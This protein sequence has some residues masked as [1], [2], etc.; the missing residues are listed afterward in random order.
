LTK[1]KEYTIGVVYLALTALC[2]GF[3][4]STVKRLGTMV[5]PYTI[6]FFRVILATAVFGV[7]AFFQKRQWQGMRWF[8]PWIFVGAVGRAGNYLLYNAGL[9]HMPSNAATILAPVQA[10]GTVLLARWFIGERTGRKWLGIALSIAGLSLIWWNGR[11]PATL[12]DLDYVAGNV[13][14]VLSGFASALQFT[15]QK[16]LSRS[17]SGVEIL[18]PVFAW[19]TVLTTP[20]AWTA[21]GFTHAYSGQ[22]WILLLFLGL[23]LTGGSFFFLGQGYARCDASTAVVITNT[24]TFLTL[25]W[26]GL[27]MNERISIAMIVGTA[28]SV[29]G[30]VSV[31]NTDRRSIQD[32]RTQT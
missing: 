9:Q 31:I 32:R 21:G 17:H 3:V 28:L 4:A 22:A 30:T 23:V 12:L 6:S 5:D 15:S 13:L 18:L 16:V 29:A 26:S 2:W 8:M 24:S 1:Q 20:F 14:L 7:L 25:L 19:S 11:G 27:L 10:I